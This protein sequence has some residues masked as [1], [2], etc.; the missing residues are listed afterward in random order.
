MEE[1][2]RKCKM[3]CSDITTDFT[4]GYLYLKSSLGGFCPTQIGWFALKKNTT[5]TCLQLLALVEYK[6]IWNMNTKP[7]NKLKRN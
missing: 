3:L 5:R 2:K 6:Y 1:K 7:P 4:S